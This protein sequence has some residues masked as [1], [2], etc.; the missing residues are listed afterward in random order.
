MGL[1][2]YFFDH[3]A[4]LLYLIAGVS[5]VIELT[6]MGLSGPLLF[7]AIA[8]FITAILTSFGLLTGWENEVFSV[9]L[10][11]GLI[12]ILLWN[13]LKKFQN[14][15][16]GPDSSSDMI[17]QQVRCTSEINQIGGTIRYSGINWTA[18]LDTAVEIKDITIPVDTLCE[19]TG[20]DG[21]VM[22][23][24]PIPN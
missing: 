14:R 8:C 2:Q 19:I 5:F 18:R 24:K 16:G 22:I 20:V 3:H 13:P 1:L 9:G 10:F 17:G 21:N 15:G 12:A 23:V 4:Q 7:F 6:I 11:T